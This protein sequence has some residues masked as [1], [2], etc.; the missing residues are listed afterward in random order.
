MGWS[1]GT[2][3]A[4]SIGVGALGITALSVP[5]VAPAFRRVCIPY[6]P[7]TPQQLANISK[8]L[9]KCHN[10]GSLIDLGSGDGRVKSL[11]MLELSLC[12]PEI[13]LVIIYS[14][15]LLS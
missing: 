13:S 3:I 11:L 6:V 1:V 10:I 15:S 9:E 12:L 2:I 5:F 8:A 7:A 14:F 4:G